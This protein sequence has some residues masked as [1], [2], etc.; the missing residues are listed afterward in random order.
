MPLTA[1]AAEKNGTLDIT[2][3]LFHHR[4]K[5]TF[6]QY[7]EGPEELLIRLM[8][9]IRK[10]PRHE[11]LNEI[12]LGRRE[13]RRFPGWSMRLLDED[14]LRGI[15]LETF[16]ESVLGTLRPELFSE[17]VVRQR[18]TGMVDRLAHQMAG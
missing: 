8:Q 3:C 17:E 1:A 15:R 5:Q 14:I 7:L 10:D 12:G 13:T 18:V 9:S 4:L 11:I 2:G 16:L 6:V